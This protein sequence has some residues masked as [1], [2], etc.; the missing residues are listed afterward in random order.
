MGWFKSLV[1]KVTKPVAKLMDP[2]LPEKAKEIANK[3]DSA[4]GG[5]AF[6][7]AFDK[8]GGYDTAKAA[9]DTATV[10]KPE[11]SALTD[12]EMTAEA[13]KRL[14]KLGKYFTTPL[15]VLQSASTGS[16]R[17]FS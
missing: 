6:G 4:V 17:T 9:A 8:P 12:D 11:I 15:G 5:I 10:A 2:L 14:A 13:Q 7:G 1:S 3:V 16:Q